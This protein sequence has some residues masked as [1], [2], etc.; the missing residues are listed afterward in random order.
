MQEISAIQLTPQTSTLA[1][2]Q[3][4][5]AANLG[6]PNVLGYIR[7]GAPG[8]TMTLRWV[9]GSTGT[10][11]ANTSTTAPGTKSAWA[12]IIGADTW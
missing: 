11:M 5:I 6:S 3:G 1:I 7:G 2:A 12:E 4:S 8:S 10:R 9:A